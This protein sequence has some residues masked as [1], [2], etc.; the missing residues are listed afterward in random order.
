[1]A[2]RKGLLG[3]KIGMTRLFSENGEVVPVT[4]IEAGP[5]HVTQIKTKA[6]DGYGALQ[7]GF[8]H[9]KRLT[10][11]ALG[12][13]KGRPPLRHL[14]E[15]RTDDA[16]DYELGQTIDVSIFESGELVDVTGM[17]KGRGFAGAVKRHGFRG[18]PKTR[19]QSDRQRA[20]GS[21]GAGTTP[22]RVFKGMRGPGHMG[23][24]R[25]TTLNL[26]VVMVDPE[27]NLLAIRGAIPGSRNGLVLIRDAVKD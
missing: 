21:I 10:K 7:I 27:R 6:R 14:R 24:R 22:G 20:V 19:G 15:I 12:H 9:A 1:M 25:V 23:N 3:R 2:N 17:S 4:V 13:L 5:C 18:G 11:P 8:G 26:A 16:A